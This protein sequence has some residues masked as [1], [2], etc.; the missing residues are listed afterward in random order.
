M[1][2]ESYLINQLAERAGV[3]VRTIRYYV[4]EGLLPPPQTKGRYSAYD[5]DYLYRIRLIKYYK[6]SYLPLSRIRELLDAM[7]PEEIRATVEKYDKEPPEFNTLPSLELSEGMEENLSARE[8]LNNIAMP[9]RLIQ[10]PKVSMNLKMLPELEQR[11]IS[12]R[13]QLTQDVSWK[14]IEVADGIELL[15]RE[16][17]Y[18]QRRREI[19]DL[20]KKMERRDWGI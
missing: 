10:E 5:E 16:D 14:R 11:R 6:E 15:V 2:K 9:K 8:Y 20:I 12:P 13:P 18:Q 7:T 3:T 4:N 1:D 17:I 19:K